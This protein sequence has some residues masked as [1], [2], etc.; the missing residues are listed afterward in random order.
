MT[1]VHINRTWPARYK[2]AQVQICEDHVHQHWIAAN[3]M[4][5]VL[6][7]LRNDL[8]LRNFH[9]SGFEK[10]DQSGRWF[11]NERALVKELKRMGSQD[12]LLFL[13][14]LEKT[15]IYPANR[16][17]AGAP[18]LQ[19]MAP[20]TSPAKLTE[21]ADT[22]PTS[23][24]DDHIPSRPLPALPRQILGRHHIGAP[25]PSGF[26]AEN[27]FEP[28]GKLLRGQL[29]LRR[30]L[31]AGC[32][33]LLGWTLL[34]LLFGMWLSNPGSYTG[35]YAL[36]QWLMVL[37]L[38][39]WSA[40]FGLWCRAVMRCALRRQSE[41]RS[42]LSSG[43]AFV[44]AVVL[45]LGTGGIVLPLVSEWAAGWWETVTYRR[46]AME[47]IHDPRLGR[48]VV[49]GPIG[50]GSYQALEKALATTPR[51]RLVEV[52]SPGGYLVESLA[53]ARLIEQQGLDTVSFGRCS[54]ACTLLLAAGQDRY[55]GPDAVLGFHRSGYRGVVASRFWSPADHQTAD[56]Y[57]SRNTAEPFVLR[58]LDT[59]FDS[60][61]T[62][63]HAA[64]YEAGFATLKWS[65]RKAGY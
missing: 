15:I 54:S 1:E 22:Q 57:R 64:M 3:E 35:E 56:F 40:G 44:A 52:Q 19:R 58:A 53:M 31:L 55:L 51:L 38:I 2:A 50:F 4:R 46:Q 62:P 25:P 30:T 12:A 45:L 20:P 33:A 21:A 10:L 13:A 18:A 61:W 28:L 49:R 36:R 59:P 14:W 27:F 11:F 6:P 60:I 29:S 7:T 63:S 65:E 8:Q 24:S 16:K 39:A 17:R 32:A 41:G 5:K 23:L 42:A 9:A 34:L 26:W 47:V 43:L 48:I 37:S